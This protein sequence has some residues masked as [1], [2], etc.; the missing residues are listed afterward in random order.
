MKPGDST[1]TSEESRELGRIREE[2]DR[3]TGRLASSNLYSLFNPAHLF[4]IQTRQRAVLKLL[5]QRGFYPLAGRV[6]VDIGCGDGNVLQEMVSFGADPDRIY[7]V[8]IYRPRL[9]QARQRLPG[10]NVIAANGQ[11]LPFPAQSF[12]VALQF[13]VFSSIL[14]QEIRKGISEEMRRVL[15]PDGLILWYD[16]WLNPTNPQTRGISRSEVRR[17]FPGQQVKFQ[18]LTLAPPITRALAG[19]SWLLCDLLESLG[20]LN[21]HYLA[22]IYSTNQ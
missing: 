4:M 19:S 10:A 5:R 16:F 21:T 18:R 14:D 22:G 11:R 7:G 1:I 15:K 2:Y 20:I 8:D 17:L 9:V 12:D 3:R 6:I 13:T